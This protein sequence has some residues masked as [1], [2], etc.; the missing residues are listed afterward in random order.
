[1]VSKDSDFQVFDRL[2]GMKTYF[3]R[4][5]DCNILV[6]FTISLYVFESICI[7]SVKP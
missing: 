3:S 7:S 4:V 1:M 5:S 6:R 2:V